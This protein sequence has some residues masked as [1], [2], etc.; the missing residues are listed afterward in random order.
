MVSKSPR[1]LILLGL[2][3]FCQLFFLSYLSGHQI[4]KVKS[5]NWDIVLMLTPWGIIKNQILTETYLTPYYKQALTFQNVQ[6]GYF[7]PVLILHLL[8]TLFFIWRLRHRLRR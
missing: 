6:S 1:Q 8:V 7:Y 3:F 4:T 2:C 5:L